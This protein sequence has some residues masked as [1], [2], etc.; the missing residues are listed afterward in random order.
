MLRYRDSADGSLVLPEVRVAG[1]RGPGPLRAV[2][3]Q[4]RSA[5]A[6]GQWWL[7]A[8]GVRPL[9]PGGSLW[10]CG[11]HGAHHSRPHPYRAIQ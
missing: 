8:R 3:Q 1:A 5:Q 11:H 6:D 4:G 9:H 10:E 2:S 7:G